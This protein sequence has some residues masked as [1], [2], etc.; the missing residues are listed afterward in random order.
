M[1]WHT[2]LWLQWWVLVLQQAQPITLNEPGDP[3][4]PDHQRL[5]PEHRLDVGDGGVL[6]E[7]EVQPGQRQA[8]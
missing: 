3:E 8:C 2:S 5:E 4:G 6:K 7:P 1:L